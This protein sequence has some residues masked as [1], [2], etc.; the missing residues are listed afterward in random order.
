L[1]DPGNVDDLM[2]SA[3]WNVLSTVQDYIS[4]ELRDMW[5]TN[6]LPNPHT[7]V[8]GNE[9]ALWYGNQG[10]LRLPSIPLDAL[11]Q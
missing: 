7:E 9:L 6:P 8:V 5:P 1:I 2:Q 4:E 11:R 3:A 10:E